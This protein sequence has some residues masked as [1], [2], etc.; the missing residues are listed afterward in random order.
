MLDGDIYRTCHQKKK[1]KIDVCTMHSKHTV[2]L[3]YVLTNVVVIDEHNSCI[4]L[5]MLPFFFFSF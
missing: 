1:K 4:F 2:P 3:L 5:F